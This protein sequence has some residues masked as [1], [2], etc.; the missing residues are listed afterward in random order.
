MFISVLVLLLNASPGDGGVQSAPLSEQAKFVAGLPAEPGSTLASLEESVPWQEHALSLDAGWA[1][2][3]TNRLSKMSAWAE[4]EIAPVIDGGLPVVYLF[5]GPDAISADVLYPGAP[6]YVL[7][8]LEEPGAMPAIESL[9]PEEIDRSL[10]A[11]RGALRTTIADSFF[12]TSRI[13]ADLKRSKLKGVLPLMMLMLARHGDEVLE[14]ERIYLA[15][16]GAVTLGTKAPPSGV[17]GLRIR[18][19]RGGTGPVRELF[20][21]SQD[22]AN[23]ALPS[24]PGLLPFLKSL[25]PYNSFFKA[26][27]FIL[28]DTH[29]SKV[30]DAVLEN[31]ESILQDDSGVQFSNL[32]PQTWSL[33]FFGEYTPA[34]GKFV[35]HFQTDLKAAWEKAEKKPLPF[36]NGYR[37]KNG[38]TMILAIKRRE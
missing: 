37:H 20:Y 18:F 31:S 21:F 28:H 15:K 7:A 14:A 4:S 23:S 17:P 38:S 3:E 24:R 32:K 27:S 10:D 9:N 29:F 6:I 1:T 35:D 16:T 11:L 30:R 26:A 36:R 5:G 8:G 33:T 2:L 19:R 25:G 12:V 34:T 13:G 22:V